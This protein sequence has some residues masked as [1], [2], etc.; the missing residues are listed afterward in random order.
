[1]TSIAPSL[2]PLQDTEI[3]SFYDC[4]DKIEEQ[5][6]D[7]ALDINGAEIRLLK[8]KNR[9]FNVSARDLFL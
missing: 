9:P 7:V 8:L 6:E 4:D 2:A 3:Y 1:M 5:R